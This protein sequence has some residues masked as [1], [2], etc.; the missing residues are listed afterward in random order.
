[1]RI[2]LVTTH[3][4]ATNPRLVKEIDLFINRGYSVTVICFAFNNWSEVLNNQLLQKFDK[5]K[6]H[7]I[8]VGKKSLFSWI[9]STIFERI[10]KILLLLFPESAMLISLS[11][12]KRSYSLKNILHNL[13][14]EFDWIIAH[15]PGS[16][17]VSKQYSCKYAIRLGID[18]EDYHPG[19]TNDLKISKRIKTYLRKTLLFSDYITAASPL[20]LQ[21]TLEDI[22]EYAGKTAI[23]LNSFSINEFKLPKVTNEKKIKLIW[24]SQHVSFERGLEHFCKVLAEYQD[25]F[26]LHLYGKMNPLFFDKVLKDLTNIIYYEPIP[27]ILLHNKLNEF[28]IGLALEPGKDLNNSLALSNKM[29]AYAQAGLYIIASDTRAQKI[30][31]DQFPA[32]GIVTSLNKNELECTLQYIQKNI[33]EIREQKSKRFIDGTVLSWEDVSEEL[34]KI[35]K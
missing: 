12:Y 33:T 19:E 29:L 3:N 1:V 31:I 13:P 35:V 6:F 26:E 22:K 23:I 18:M 4:L 34:I 10:S 2:L 30:M 5:A 24:F 17:W 14:N 8:P 11:Y 15:N 25:V 21:Y 7:V 9:M 20:I 32:M 27:Q 16:F 28:D